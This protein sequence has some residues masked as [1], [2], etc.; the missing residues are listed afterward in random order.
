LYNS[1]NKKLYVNDLNNLH[2]V[3]ATNKGSERRQISHGKY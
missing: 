2:K 3:I 1:D